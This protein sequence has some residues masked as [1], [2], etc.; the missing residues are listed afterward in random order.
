MGRA[1]KRKLDRESTR[2]LRR[3]GR[4]A[5]K[6]KTLRGKANRNMKAETLRRRKQKWEG[7]EGESQIGNGTGTK[8]VLQ[9]MT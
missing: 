6:S 3:K 9:G 7:R 4:K 8:E 5:E 1:K 2:N